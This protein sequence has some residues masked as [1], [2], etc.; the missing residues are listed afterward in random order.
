MRQI[1]TSRLATPCASSDGSGYTTGIFEAL[2]TTSNKRA[3]L[4]SDLFGNFCESTSNTS[5]GSGNPTGNVATC[6]YATASCTCTHNTVLT[7]ARLYTFPASRI[8]PATTT[9]FSRPQGARIG[10]CIKASRPGIRQL[11]TTSTDV[12]LA[13]APLRSISS[14]GRL[15][16]LSNTY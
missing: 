12:I 7:T 13:N 1:L 2:S 11:R 6:G 5:H 16:H 15:Y 3:L 4:A 10:Q 14:H 9:T 8:G